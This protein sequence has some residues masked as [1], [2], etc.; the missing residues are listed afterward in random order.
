[1]KSVI[2]LIVSVSL[3]LNLNYAQNARYTKAMEKAVTALNEAQDVEGFMAAKNAFERIASAEKEEWLPLYYQSYAHL[4]AGIKLM[5]KGQIK[6]CVAHVKKADDKIQ[7]A[8][9]IAPQE[10]ELFALQAFILQGYIWEDP[11][12]NGAQYTPMIMQA[13][14]T[15]I[16]LNPKNPR[17]FCVKGQ[18]LY[19]MPAFIGGGPEA[20]K[21][22]LEKAITKFEAFEPASSIHPGWGKEMAAELLKQMQ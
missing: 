11:Q 10:S 7:Q 22:F 12:T 16:G 1:M 18:Q 19:H 9:K 17:G 2:A 5:E 8:I 14:E 3:F 21:P 4:Q 15:A 20:A 6:D 13:V